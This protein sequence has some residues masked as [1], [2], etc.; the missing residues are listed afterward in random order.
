[1]NEISTTIVDGD[2][3]TSLQ[4]AEITARL[5][6]NVMRAIRNME[7][8][9]EKINGRKFELVDYK[10]E[11]GETRPCYSL[12]KEECLYIATKFNDEARAKLI[13]RWKE[14][15]EQ[16]KPSV[17]QN[18]L[19]ALESLVKAE[20]EKQQL[21]LENKQKDETIITISKANVELGNK[22]TEML[23]KV[24]YYDRILQSNATMTIT[25][26]AQD[27]GMSAIAMNKELES[28]RIQHKERGQWILYAQF[29]KGGYVHS[30]AV[31]IIR[32]DG[33]HDVK[34]NT[35]WTTKGRLFLY[36]A[37][38]GKGILPLIEQENT[39]R[40]E[41]TGGREPSKTAS[42]S[43]QTINFE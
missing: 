8:A 32:R 31:D 16:S 21:A 43:Q 5:H 20:K 15:E 33:R 17:P 38:K 14:L 3:M 22:I 42:A 6:K 40:G 1:M 29:L 30:R 25:Q 13:K 36:E 34:Y 19:E 12:N 37:L 39:P 10:D 23:P 27:Y 2:R 41:D 35:E 18:Y 9:W 11:K 4:I 26:I 7:P 24:S 28:M